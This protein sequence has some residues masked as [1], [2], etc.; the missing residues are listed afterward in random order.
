MEEALTLTRFADQVTIV[1]RKDALH[2]ASQL[3]LEQVENHPKIKILCNSQIVEVLGDNKVEAV[4][5]KDTKTH[6][7]SEMPIE[8]IFVAISRVPKSEMFKEIEKDEQG[9]IRA[10]EMV[11]T[12]IEGVFVAGDVHNKPFQ[13]AVVAAGFG[14]MAGLEVKR[15]L[16]S[17]K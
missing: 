11:K 15:Y 17:S 14:A 12:N 2:R 10:H 8:G 13:Q 6:K 3:L 1:Y 5:L 16:E 4:M 9:Y 7:V